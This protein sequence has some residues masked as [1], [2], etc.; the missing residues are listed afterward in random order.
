MVTEKWQYSGLKYENCLHRSGSGSGLEYADC[1]QK[2]GMRS[3]LSIQNISE[4]DFGDHRRICAVGRA[5][6]VTCLKVTCLSSFE[7]LVQAN[8]TSIPD[9]FTFKVYR[10]ITIFLIRRSCL[11]MVEIKRKGNKERVCNHWNTYK[12]GPTLF[13]QSCS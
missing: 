2:S 9:P 8:V 5:L 6:K 7:V 12:R 13:K 4:A 10:S 11:C 3:G 1:L